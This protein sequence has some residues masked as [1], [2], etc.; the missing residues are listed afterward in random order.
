MCMGRKSK[1]R[2]NP[3]LH[4]LRQVQNMISGSGISLPKYLSVYLLTCL[5]FLFFEKIGKRTS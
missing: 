3:V 2:K 4:V 1:L 5:S